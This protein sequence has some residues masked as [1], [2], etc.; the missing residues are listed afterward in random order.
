MNN[1]LKEL[2]RPMKDLE[3][4]E[5]MTQTLELNGWDGVCIIRETSDKGICYEGSIKG[6][7][8]LRNISR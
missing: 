5:Q 7:G 1:T 2:D 6:S 8:I 3:Y 4:A